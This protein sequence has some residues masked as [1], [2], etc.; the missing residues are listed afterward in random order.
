ME[1]HSTSPTEINP[2]SKKSDTLSKTFLQSDSV[3]LSR[4]IRLHQSK[5]P[6]RKIQKKD[7]FLEKITSDIAL[8]ID[9]L[10]NKRKYIT[11]QSIAS[12]KL[13]I[14]AL[15]EKSKL[16]ISKELQSIFENDNNS[17]KDVKI[18]QLKTDKFKK[19]IDDFIFDSVITIRPELRV[20]LSDHIKWE[21][22][23]GP[24]HP[25]CTLS[26]RGITLK[27]ADIANGAFGS[28]S[29]F[30]NKD[31]D[32]F[33]GKISKNK[34][35]GRNGRVK[36]DLADEMKAYQTIYKNPRLGPHPNLVNV[37]GIAII[38]TA[39]G[40]KRTLLME[41]VPGP[42][43]EK[44]FADLRSAWDGGAISTAEYY[45]AH[46]FIGRKLLAVTEHLG[47]AGIVHND[48]KPENFLVNAKTGEP[49]L[50]DLGLWKKKG[51]RKIAGTPI[52]MSPEARNGRPL[53][54][55]SDLFTIGATLVNGIEGRIGF[56]KNE[57]IFYNTDTA[58]YYPGTEDCY[59]VAP[60][61]GLYKRLT[62]IRDD[63]NKVQHQP[64]TYSVNLAY[65]D[66]VNK[67]LLPEPHQRI[68]FSE[69]ADTPFFNDSIL[70]DAE[71]KRII[72]KVIAISNEK[73]LPQPLKTRTL[74][75]PSPANQN[76]IILE[77]QACFDRL[78]IVPDLRDFSNLQKNAKSDPVLADFLLREMPVDVQQIVEW[79]SHGY[80]DFLETESRQWM[81]L[82]IRLQP[83][84]ASLTVKSGVKNTGVHNPDTV[85]TIKEMKE[86][87]LHIAEE[88]S[89]KMGSQLSMDELKKYVAEATTFLR[90]AANVKIIDRS[91]SAKVENFS[92]IVSTI[93]QVIALD[94]ETRISYEPEKKID[95]KFMRWLLTSAT[96]TGRNLIKE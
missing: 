82:A 68:Q 95:M 8:D 63:H 5:I 50:I 30:T 91:L 26:F 88:L 28:V 96:P 61:D 51:G 3:T 6:F 58:P 81:D 45:S 24:I 54:E 94:A 60:K 69:I 75:I 19:N 48:I 13:D 9:K 4:S 16:S 39:D 62:T 70:D 78:I 38:P 29:I 1:G 93:K 37:Y 66:A 77:N 72:S 21:A 79:K 7:A 20:A 46:Q 32:T 27:T 47:K 34:M 90:D 73:R 53:S 49:I 36:D 64:G 92:R 2:N 17:D 84:I 42:S 56:K 10:L 65:S 41:K 57:E 43:G 87:Q 55:L 25:D 85:M 12:L 71:A 80:V 14:A 86:R 44:L 18:K 22:G 59:N 67:M 40:P 89:K 74:K 23:V 33:I 52:F 11:E 31:G 15:T 83:E 35:I 76:K